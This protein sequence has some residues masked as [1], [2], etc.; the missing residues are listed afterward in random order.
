MNRILDSA[1]K[2]RGVDLEAWE[3]ALRVAVLEAGAK[4]LGRLLE[5]IGCGQRSEPVIC[6]CGEAM[7]SRGLKAKP[8]LSILG[9]MDYRRSMFQCPTCHAVRYPG[10]EALD[11]CSTTHSPGVRWMMARAGSRSTFREGREDLRVYAG[12]KVSAKD[13]ERVAE[14]TGEGVE[15]WAAKEREILIKQTPPA[16]RTVEIPIMYVSY[17]GTGVPMIPTAVQ[18][19]KG[20][21]PDGSA[22]TREV[23]LGCVFTQSTTDQDGFP[24]RDPASTT[25]VGAIE[26]SEVFGWHIYAEAVRRGLFNARQVVVLGDG[27]LWIRNLAELHFPNAIQIIDLYHAREHLSDLCK[28]LGPSAETTVIQRRE[29]WWKLL[30]A[31]DVETI[32]SEARDNLPQE[33]EAQ[34]NLPQESEAR[35]NLP[36]KPDA[37]E[38]TAREKAES[39]TTYFEN[40]C[41]RMR[42]AKYRA[43]GLF[44][45]SGVI[46]AGC[47]TVIGHR[48]KQSG[49]EWSVRGA[50]SII[51]LRCTV[52]SGRFESYWEDRVA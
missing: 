50:N 38:R 31:G 43:L 2:A 21:Q 3:T 9:A 44:V 49:M 52:Y 16:D 15:G 30:D 24:I 45:G 27:S 19:R 34:G 33:S 41:D 26:T 40:N 13:L 25:F 39:E 17:D 23:K 8:I 46:E 5:G 7:V 35:D 42:Y 20:K 12:I 22:C 14:A 51:S 28:I 1:S 11:I 36:P 48:L 4:A 32:L 18:G 47:K 6:E 10:D 37:R 29:R